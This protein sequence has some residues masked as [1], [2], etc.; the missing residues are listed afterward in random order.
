MV[1]TLGCRCGGIVDSCGISMQGT[2]DL[3]SLP[4]ATNAEDSLCMM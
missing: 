4:S 2:A 3:S 1:F